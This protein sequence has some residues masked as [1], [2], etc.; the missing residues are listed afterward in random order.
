[1][2]QACPKCGHQIVYVK[3]SRGQKM[4]INSETWR[5]GESDFV[6]EKHRIH[7]PFCHGKKK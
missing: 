3:N 5:D 7:L 1:V 6:Y 2:R 4:A